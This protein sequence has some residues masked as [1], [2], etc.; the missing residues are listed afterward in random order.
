M[1][2]KINVAELLADGGSSNSVLGEVVKKLNEVIEKLNSADTKEAI[3]TNINN[4]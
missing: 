2:D 4:G 1:I 3:S